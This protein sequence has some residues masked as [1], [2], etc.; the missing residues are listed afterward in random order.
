MLCT[1]AVYVIVLVT[2]I[3]TLYLSFATVR[4]KHFS[5]AC[6]CHKLMVHVTQVYAINFRYCSYCWSYHFTGKRYNHLPLRTNT[7][8]HIHSHMQCFAYLRKLHHEYLCM[9]VCMQYVN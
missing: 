9:Y 5:S 6:S 7:H 4:S 2:A 1:N 8:K 3:L